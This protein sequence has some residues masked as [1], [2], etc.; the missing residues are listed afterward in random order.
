MVLRL[1]GNGYCFDDIS[2]HIVDTVP[3]QSPHIPWTWD[4]STK[5]QIRI[6]ISRL[7]LKIAAMPDKTAK[8]IFDGVENSYMS[9]VIAGI[10]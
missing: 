6:Q 3:P 10:L 2:K 8:R 9:H 5:D 1:K 7:K 4:N